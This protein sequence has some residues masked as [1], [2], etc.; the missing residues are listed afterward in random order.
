MD[1][2]AFVGWY[3]VQDRALLL[4]RTTRDEPLVSWHQEYIEI[5]FQAWLCALAQA[6]WSDAIEDPG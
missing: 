4:P 6:V 5:Q 1:A 2:F 3:A